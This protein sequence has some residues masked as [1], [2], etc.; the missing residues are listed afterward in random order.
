[1]IVP[2]TNRDLRGPKGTNP[3]RHELQLT[4]LVK[5]LG[6][7]LDKGLTWKAHLENVI[8]KAHRTCKGTSGKTW[9]LK[10]RVLHWIY[11]MVIRLILTYGSMV[12]WPTVRF[13]VN[14][15]ELNKLQR[16]ACLAI[17]GATRM[18]PT[19][20]VVVL[21]GFLPLHVVPEVGAQAGIYRP[22]CNHQWKLKSTNYSYTKKSQDMEYEP[23]LLSG[24]EKMI[25]IYAYHKPFKVQLPNKHEQQNAFNS[26]NM[27][28][29]S[30]KQMGI[31]WK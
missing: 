9:A 3:S 26:D 5:C 23:T 24:T 6:F 27:E 20:A 28:T 21:L 17:T 25:L 31:Q 19:A 11:T 15:M 13:N 1:V 22:M 29:W 12:W 14:R 7:T 10:P 2:F 18:I 4:S 30:G 8:N 16:L